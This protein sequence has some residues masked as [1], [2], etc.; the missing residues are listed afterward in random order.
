LL[1]K[2]VVQGYNGQVKFA[3]EN[4]GESK[5]AEQFGVKRYPV[6]F[7]ENVLVAKPDDFGGWGKPTGRYAPWREVSS[8]ERFKKD[9]RQVIDLALRNRIDLAGKYRVEPDNTE[10]ASLPAFT[11]QN[12]KGDRVESASLAGQVVL[13]EFWATWCVPCRSTLGWLGEVERRYGDK[14][15]VIAMA[16][17]SEEAEVRKLVESLNLPV[18]TTMGKEEVVASF[19]T[20][21]SV[22][23]MFVFDRQG[24][25]AS[26]FYGAPKDLHKRVGSLIETLVR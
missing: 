17:D 15:T 25:T 24:K 26:V 21:T 5:L 19:G 22:P 20:V 10:L 9:L 2:D 11:L 23:T 14:V 18:H 6:V 3:S 1:I 16:L 12:L 8:H 13:V 7:V 4:W